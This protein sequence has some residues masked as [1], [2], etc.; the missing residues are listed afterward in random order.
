MNFIKKLIYALLFISLSSTSVMIG[1]KRVK[2]PETVNF[3]GEETYKINYR[4]QIKVPFSYSVNKSRVVSASLH[5]STGK[6]LAGGT[7][8]VDKGKG[9]V[10]VYLGYSKANIEPGK[11]YEIR[12]HIRKVGERYTWRDAIV[13]GNKKGIR[14]RK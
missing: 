11:N 2:A 6:W 10:E 7:E 13:Q 5:N 12:Y 3:E 9:K 8:I 4:G 1:Q 14:V